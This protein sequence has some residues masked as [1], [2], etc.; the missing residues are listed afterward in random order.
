MK[1]RERENSFFNGGTTS[2]KSRLAS[3]VQCTVNFLNLSALFHYFIALSTNYEM[4]KVFRRI[5]KE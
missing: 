2:T 5:T 1:Q 3:K 4:K